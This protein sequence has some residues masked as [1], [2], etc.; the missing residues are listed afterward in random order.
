[1][2]KKWQESDSGDNKIFRDNIIVADVVL[3]CCG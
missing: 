1:M 2:E 3:C